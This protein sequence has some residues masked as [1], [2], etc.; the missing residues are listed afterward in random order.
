[1]TA[2]DVRLRLGRLVAERLDAI[3]AGLGANAAYMRDL[4]QELTATRASYVGLAVTEIATLRR[5]LGG[6]QTG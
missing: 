5:Q 3:E 2:H 1:M 4:E 6:A